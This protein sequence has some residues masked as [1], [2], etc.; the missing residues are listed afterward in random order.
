MCLPASFLSLRTDAA[1][2]HKHWQ[3]WEKRWKLAPFSDLA[4]AQSALP[5]GNMPLTT[6]LAKGLP[7]GCITYKER[8]A[9]YEDDKYRSELLVP[10]C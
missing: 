1:Y 4:K 6:P 9:R 8:Y 2:Q 10:L 3:N 7:E 5:P